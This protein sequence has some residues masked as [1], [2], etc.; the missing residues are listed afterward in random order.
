[1]VPRRK[2]DALASRAR[3]HDLRE[4]L[5]G[6]LTSGSRPRAPRE[7]IAASWAR[8]ALAGLRPEQF[9][10]PYAPDVDDE[11]PFVSAAA[12]VIDRVTEDLDGSGIALLLTDEH[13]HVVARRSRER[14]VRSLLDRIELAPGFV[15]AEPE[16]GTNAIGTAIA[17]A[18][19]SVVNGPEHFADALVRMACTAVPITDAAG[20]VRGV[21]DLTCSAESFSP[22]MLPLARR[23]AAE[24]E[25]RLRLGEGRL[26]MAGWSALSASE[27]R[28]A[29]LV[30]GGLTNRE[31]AR[32]LLVRPRSVD[33]HLRNIFRKL[34]VHSRAGLIRIAELDASRARIL[35]AGDEAR[36]RIERDLHDG[37]QQ[38]LVSL[39]IR[40][41]LVQD[42]VKPDD[43]QVKDELARLADG[44][45]DV[46]ENLRDI[47]RG[48]HPAVLSQA[49]LGPALKV[50][51]RRSTVPVN[52]DVRVSGRLAEPIEIGAYYVVSEA[53]ANVAKH[54]S[55]TAVDVSVEASD[56]LLSLSVRDD[57]SGGADPRGSGLSG[58]AERVEALGGAFRIVSPP[59]AG[60]LVRL[61]LPLV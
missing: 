47:A 20:R 59:G 18:A 23:A 51:A 9:E 26:P 37:L 34:D 24:I 32:E 7:D 19:P 44:V 15:Y 38:Q 48:I 5:D 3:E 43:R 6:F 58:L 61:T 55:A 13:G 53:L 46:L 36:Q 45:Q 10:V 39:G 14:G 42:A 4:Q 50:L 12:S 17:Q 41:N 49:G 60:T 54:A 25:Q 31:V 29:S 1:V 27:R 8:S 56:D 40:L 22:L 35:A 52:L 11:G 16:V 21:V 2:A 57:G 33:S 28:V 30:A